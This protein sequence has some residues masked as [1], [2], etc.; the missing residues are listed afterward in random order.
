[1]G[2]PGLATFVLY[3]I[4]VPGT[5]LVPLVGFRK[6]RRDARQGLHRHRYLWRVALHVAWSLG[7]LV[8]TLWF[9]SLPNGG[10]F[11]VI[12]LPGLSVALVRLVYELWVVETLIQR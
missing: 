3:G 11:A 12:L 6:L 1:M 10:L 4:I 2:N 5:L 9:R 7:L 8:L